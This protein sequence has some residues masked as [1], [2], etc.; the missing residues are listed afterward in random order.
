MTMRTQRGA[1]GS[2]R[3]AD[4]AHDRTNL[5]IGL[6]LIFLTAALYAPV[7]H[8][9]FLAYDDPTYV[10]ENPLVAGGLT[11]A[12]LVWAWTGIHQ[13]T[14]H[15]LTTL[16]HMLDCQLF[17]LHPG[18][19]HAGNVVLH[20]ANAVLL[21]GFLASTTHQRWRSA[22]VAALFA[23]HPLH[24]ESVAWISERKDV[25]STCFFLLTLCA[26]ATYA[27]RP[28]VQRYALV[29][30]TYAAA[31]LSKPM[32][33][34]LP[35]VLL[36]LD[37][38]PLRR[39]RGDDPHAA[40]P[41]LSPAALLIEKLPLLFLA[42]AV[43]VVTY[44]TQQRVGAV[45]G[46]IAS[47]IAGRVA[48]ALV[49]YAT[50][51]VTTFWPA[52]LAVF[53]PFDGALPLWQVLAAAGLLSGISLVVGWRARGAPYLLVG[54]LW[55]L[56]TLVPVI[57]F[58]R[59]GAQ[60]MAD[61]FTYIPLIGIFIITVWGIADR[62]ARRRDGH[63]VCC[64]AAVLAVAGSTVLAA[65]QLAYW[66][67][68]MSLFQHAVD[69]TRDNYVAHGMLGTA[70]LQAGR[71]DDAFAHLSETVRIEPSSYRENH[72]LGLILAARGDLDGAKRHYLAALRT[73]PG[74]ADAYNSLGVVLA[75][76]GDLAKAVAHYRQ[77]I[78]LDPAFAAAHNNLAATLA[79]MGQADEALVEYTEAIRLS[80]QHAEPH[81][82][83]GAAPESTGH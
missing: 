82:N 34:T 60:A 81:A 37:V 6:G 18:W 75:A 26:Y 5:W 8:Y 48:N 83:P 25:L 52:R 65:R 1:V 24:V 12:G 19:H 23:V 78:R 68:T 31:L 45:T 50:Y 49:A 4:R 51:L 36:L 9:D 53:Y 64:V 55:Y 76:Q 21:F 70:L 63:I 59:A 47:P 28:Q 69:V 39:L 33:V 79:Q 38:W 74:F 29:V 72:S 22:V 10:T 61:R 13:A 14:W 73:S 40:R 57:G 7:R 77:A 66:R 16:S 54:W 35:F 42:A 11:G 20:I 32:V 41:R 30:L 27:R 71:A 17:G 3:R 2:P 58:V 62:V 43:A 44:V 67:D 46:R 15:P 56:G 80:A